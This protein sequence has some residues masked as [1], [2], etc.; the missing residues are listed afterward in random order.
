MNLIIAAI[1]LAFI[2]AAFEHFIGLG[3]PWK[4]I[5]IFGI[6]VIFIVGLILLLLPGLLPL[7][8]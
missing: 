1:V 5:A 7:R 3:E 6:V 4:K 8:V 2:A